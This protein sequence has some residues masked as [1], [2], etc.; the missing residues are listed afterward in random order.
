MEQTSPEWVVTQAHDVSAE[1]LA[2]E[3]GVHPL[4]ARILLQRGIGDVDQAA[5]FLNPSLKQM[6]DPFGMKGMEEAVVEVLTAIDR[7]ERIMI[8]GDYDVDGVCSVALLYQFLRQLGA[9]VEYTIPQRD[10]DGYGLNARSVRRFA[11]QGV[12]LVITTDCGVS[13]VEEI[14]LARELGLKVVVVD[15]HTVPPVLPPA[16]AILNPLQPGCGFAFKQL[17]AVGVT[18]CLVVALRATLRDHGV[19]KHIPEPDIREYLDLVALGTVADVVPLIDLNRIFVRHGLEVLAG[20]RRAGISALMER[21]RVDQGPISP[22]T[23]S[24]RLAPRLNAAGRMGDAS[25]CVELLT[26]ESYARAIALARELE[27]QNIARQGL[28]RELLEWAIPQAEREVALGRQMLVVAGR[29]W[30]RGVLG[31]VASRLVER[32]HRP[33]AMVGIDDEG[34]GK[35]S[36]RSIE[37]INVIEVLRFS[38]DLLET[39]GGHTA[40]AGLSL[41]EHNVDA[42]RDRLDDGLCRGLEGRVLPQRKLAIDCEVCLGELDERFGHDLRRLG[43]FGTGNREPVLLCRQSQASHVRVVGNN[44]LKAKFRGGG[45]ALDG[46]GFSMAE[47]AA[48][49]N[50]PVAVAFVPRFAT[51]RGRTRLEMH[52][53]G[54]RRADE[55]CPDRVLTP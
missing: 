54:L 55:H 13:N 40:A 49:L 31:I 45:N 11:E 9:Q 37:G 14:G 6:A 48:L 19:F 38:A 18:F 51:F 8:H 30:H 4:T 22:Q 27:A 17:A 2:G 28:E 26:T 24:F 21:A 53:R 33:V 1:A 44:H 42:L 41:L 25:I 34:V 16:N 12:S 47:E 20:R 3:L 36:V 29:G 43:P 10:Q 35:G 5:R 15:H 46:I 23:I 32:F 39:F 52:I 50:V 7:G